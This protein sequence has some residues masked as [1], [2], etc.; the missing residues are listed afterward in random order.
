MVLLITKKAT[1]EQI[2]KM[3]RHFSGYIKIVVDLEKEILAGGADRHFEEEKALLENGSGQKNLWGG[4]YD[5]QTK[6]IDYNSVINLRPNQNNPSRD[7][8]DAKARK[9]FAGIVKKLLS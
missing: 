1:T 4:G 2:K 5:S 7:I 8:L 3:G 9:K 6:E